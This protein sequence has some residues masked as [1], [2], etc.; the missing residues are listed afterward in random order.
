[1]QI[2]IRST[3]IEV[4]R[5]V[6]AHIERR[7]QF[8]LGRLSQHILRVTVNIVDINGPRAG[9]DKNCRIE[10][11][12]LP[13]GTVFVEDTDANLYTAV[14]RA[15]ERAARSVIRAIKR[16]RDVERDTP[17]PEGKWPSQTSSDPGERAV[18]LYWRTP[19]PR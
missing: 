18:T 11:R 14:D 5:A 1:M 16:A 4:D 8:S 17:P 2:Q 6:H 7:L 15:A 3:Q 10:V 19:A 13:T 9:V 12:L